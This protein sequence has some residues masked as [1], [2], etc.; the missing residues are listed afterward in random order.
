MSSKKILVVGS[1][2]HELADEC[3]GWSQSTYSFPYLGDYHILIVNLH[4]LYES[5]LDDS[6]EK[7]FNKIRSQI[8]EII[9]ANTEIVCITAPTIN[10]G[11]FIATQNGGHFPSM[12][13]YHWSPIYL[14]F[15][16]EKGESFEKEP[17]GGYFDFIKGWTHF[18]DKWDTELYRLQKGDY[19]VLNFDNLLTNLAKKRLSFSVRFM[20]FNLDMYGR[21][22]G[23]ILSNPI[24][25]LPPPTKISVEEA[26]D[27][28]LRQQRGIRESERIELPEWSKKILVAGEEEIIR[29]IKEK[30]ALKNQYEKEL[31]THSSKLL[32]ITQYKALLTEEGERLENIVEKGFEILNVEVKPGPKVKEDRI[33]TDPLSREQIPM[34]ITGSEK[35]IPERKLN[36]L[37]G[38]LTDERRPEKIECRGI[39]VGN[40]YRTT[41]LNEY[42]QGRKA[43][44]EPDVVK[45]AK[46]FNICLLSTTELFK[47][48]NAKF[49]AKEV[50][51]FVK[52]IFNNPGEVHFEG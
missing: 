30:E 12:S 7:T 39:L 42:L 33:I 27:Y 9:W 26:I 48:I 52:A 24:V 22:T 6:M 37:I 11:G 40:H 13:N 17:K 34:E 19:V 36:Q 14:N 49:Q 8:N 3:V 45:K 41:P 21:R 35:S 28:L 43:A 18:L 15:V 20:E 38:R 32:E 4:S 29:T 10:K 46:V 2:G 50:I 31:K 47:A 44:F 51:D 5:V 25:F 23:E 16:K 1:Y